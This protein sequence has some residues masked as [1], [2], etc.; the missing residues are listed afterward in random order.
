[1]MSSKQSMWLM[2]ERCVFVVL[3]LISVFLGSYLAHILRYTWMETPFIVASV[4]LFL[5]ALIGFLSTFER[6]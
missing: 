5:Y 6:P 3:W 4:A 1:M 2:G